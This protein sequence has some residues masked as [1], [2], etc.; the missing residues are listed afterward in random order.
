MIRKLCAVFMRNLTARLVIFLML[1]LMLIMGVYDYN[2]LSQERERLVAQ[3]QE[4]VRIFSETLA[5]AVRQNVRLG[6]TTDELRE[7]LDEILGRPGLVAVVIFGPGGGLVAATVAPGAEPPE[8][9]ALVQQTLSSR[10]AGVA[11][12]ELKSGRVLRHVQPFRWPV[13][14]RTA[15]IEVR[16]TL[17]GMEQD[18]RRAIRE[19]IISRLLVLAAFVLSVVALTRWNI[20]RP[21]RSLIAGAQAIGHGDLGQRIEVVR[22]DEIGQ[23]AD[24]FNR[25]ACNLQEANQRLIHEATERLRLEQEA[26]QAQKLAAVGMLAAKVAHEIGTPL[27]VIS[28]RAEVLARSLSSEQPG[29]RHLDVILGQTE[30]IARIIRTLLDYTRPKQPD[31]QPVEVL[32]ILGRVASMLMDRSRRREVRI[33]LELPTGLPAVKADPDQLQQLF[34]NLVQNALDVSPP[35]ASVRLAAGDESLLPAEGR[36]AVRRGETDADCLA[37]HVLDQGG[38]LTAE[39]LEKVFEP[40]FSTKSDGRGTGLGLAIVEEI[41]RSHRGAVELASVPG[42]GSE[43]IVRLPLAPE[44]PVEAPP[45]A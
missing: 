42:R 40:F 8:A 26:Q 24:E 37:L 41:V 23:L 25:M 4:D 45:H 21:I 34:L 7:L 6:R 11:T 13:A 1:A 29:R 30:R 35:G 31:L 16:Q 18:F 19:S 33:V 2:R 27:N 44:T 20:S 22:R 10:R 15:A 5:L 36:A 32:P 12:V 39:E 14:G 17:A 38:G 3:M 9:D 28:G 43:A